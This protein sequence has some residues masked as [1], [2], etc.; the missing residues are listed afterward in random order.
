MAQL[1]GAIPLYVKTFNLK[2]NHYIWIKVISGHKDISSQVIENPGKT[3]YLLDMLTIHHA[4]DH[5]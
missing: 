5:Q 3:S 2:H 4:E 1:Q